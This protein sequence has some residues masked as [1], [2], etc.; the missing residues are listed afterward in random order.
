MNLLFITEFFPVDDNLQ[1][2]GGVEAHNFYL[3]KEL[4]KKHQVTVIC[5]WGLNQTKQKKTWGMEIIRL[6]KKQSR[7]D[8]GISTIPDRVFFMWQSFW[9]GKQLNFDIVQGN[10]FTCYPSAFLLGLFQKKPAIAWYPDVFLGKWVKLTNPVSGLLGATAEKI[11]LSLNW[12]KIISLSYSTT[13][14][15]LKQN[16]DLQRVT[17]IPGGVDVSFFSRTKAAKNKVFTICCVARLVSYKRIDLLIKAAAI[18]QKKGINFQIEIIG[19]GPED[20]SLKLLAQNL[21]V[22]KKIKFRKNLSRLELANTLKRA[23]LFCLPSEQEGFGLVVIEAAS[24]GLPYIVSD[25]KVFKEVTNNGQ[26]GLFFKRGNEVDLAHKLAIVIN[27]KSLLQKLGLQ[28]LKLAKK[29]DWKNVAV[30]FEKTYYKI[31]FKPMKILMLVDAWFPLTGGGQIHAWELSKQIADQGHR[32]LIFTRDLGQWNLNYP[33]IKVI[34]VGHFKKFANI[35]GRLEYLVLA[36]IYSLF[37]DYDVW[38]AHAFSPGLLTPFVKF[39]RGK[40]TV[41]T[42]HGAGLQIAGLG[43]NGKW[44]DNLLQEIVFYKMSYEAEI[45]VAKKTFTQK[46]LA[47]KIIVI[48]NGV[49][50]NNWQK[51]QR[52]RKEVKHLLYVGRIVYDKGVDLL[53]EAFSQL[54]NMDLTVVGEGDELPKLKRLTRGRKVKFVGRLEGEKL[55]AEFKKADLL[56]MPSRVEGMPLRLLEAWA[57]K[58]PV[59][60]TKVGDNEVYIKEGRNGFLADVET[61]SIQNAIIKASQSNLNQITERGWNDVQ[62]FTWTKIADKTINVYEEV[63]NEKN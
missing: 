59:V 24:A 31:L 29:Y 19:E 45:T 41:F 26:G 60:A 15:L 25:I 17:T 42:A 52:Q 32:V 63:L 43:A 44:L 48:P 38:H 3:F 62:K 51:A 5:R 4:A 13:E 39:F 47:K 22:E 37:S 35:F 27:N 58:L 20:F 34:R 23:Q 18:L 12:K 33:N 54:K 36:L 57:A 7:I 56:V 21:E 8:S 28:A 2:S 10:N 53:M 16:V 46:S 9:F 1:F 61:S 50:I 40:P 30:E 55:A 11:Y 6:G 49:N 14:K